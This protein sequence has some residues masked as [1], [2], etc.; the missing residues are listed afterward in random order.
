MRI[1]GTEF[2]IKEGVWIMS[3]REDFFR[4]LEGKKPLHDIPYYNMMGAMAGQK[5]GVVMFP[6]GI[7]DMGKI[8]TTGYDSWGLEYVMD[9]YKMGFIHKPGKILLK[10][11]RQWRDVVKAPDHSNYDWEAGAE[12]DLANVQFD[13]ETQVSYV[14]YGGDFFLKLVGF[15]GFEGALVAMYEEPTAVKEM[16]D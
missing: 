12:K 11:V 1:I 14:W 3:F 5:N 13:K 2:K 6:L 4:I 10:D 8:A 16:F 9:I 15:M 7:A